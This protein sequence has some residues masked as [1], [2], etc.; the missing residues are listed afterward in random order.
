MEIFVSSGRRGLSVQ[1]V[2]NL[3][4]GCSHPQ[5]WLEISARLRP[6]LQCFLSAIPDLRSVVQSD[7]VEVRFIIQNRPTLIVQ[8]ALTP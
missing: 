6:Y 3:R 8:L 2:H 1:H 7:V 5:L 4:N